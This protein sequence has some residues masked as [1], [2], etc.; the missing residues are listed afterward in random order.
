MMMFR[1]IIVMSGN[2]NAICA[3][4]RSIASGH[5][6]AAGAKWFTVLSRFG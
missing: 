2:R 6:A 4:A 1:L 5:V 3:D